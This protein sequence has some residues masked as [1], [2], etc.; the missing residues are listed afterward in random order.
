MR[1]RGE[2]WKMTL[3][4]GEG[5]IALVSVDMSKR[6]TDTA[7]LDQVMASPTFWA[8]GAKD[9]SVALF[10]GPLKMMVLLSE[11]ARP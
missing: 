8:R 7:A 4:E 1:Q 9:R 3:Q 5:E 2:D 11:M 6:A 10:L